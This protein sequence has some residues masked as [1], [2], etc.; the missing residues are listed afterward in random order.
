LAS[1]QCLSKAG[2]AWQRRTRRVSRVPNSR[3]TKPAHVLVDAKRHIIISTDVQW[4]IQHQAYAQRC[5]AR[6]IMRW[7]DLCSTKGNLQ[8][9][10]RT[11][12]MQ[13]ACCSLLAAIAGGSGKLLSAALPGRYSFTCCV[14]RRSLSASHTSI[15]SIRHRVLQYSSGTRS[16]IPATD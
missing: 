12:R 14:L 10:S 4:S 3:V 5:L 1:L 15:R 8:V 7:G 9:L 2:V 11:P 6:F 16:A 13:S